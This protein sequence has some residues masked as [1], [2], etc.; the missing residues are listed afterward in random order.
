VP[1]GG[2]EGYSTPCSLLLVAQ[3]TKNLCQILTKRKE[4]RKPKEKERFH[5]FFPLTFRERDSTS[6]FG[7]GA[8]PK[9]N[10]RKKERE[11]KKRE[12]N[13]SKLY[14]S[15]RTLP[16]CPP[17]FPNNEKSRENKQGRRGEKRD[18]PN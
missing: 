18:H 10:R 17:K 9:K 1:C 13:S 15:P 4:R 6:S 7:I 12:K 5:F 3:T 11:V 16:D 2:G 8:M 14:G